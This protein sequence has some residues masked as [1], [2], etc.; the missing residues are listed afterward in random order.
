[1]I[2]WWNAIGKGSQRKCW[3]VANEINYF[4]FLVHTLRSDS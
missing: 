3:G 2:E 1:M 4:S